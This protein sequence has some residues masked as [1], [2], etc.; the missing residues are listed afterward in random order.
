MTNKDADIK[1]QKAMNAYLGKFKEREMKTTVKHV[2]SAL[3]EW[4]GPEEDSIAHRDAIEHWVNGGEVENDAT[5]GWMIAH[6]SFEARV[7]YRIKQREPKPG[8]V[9]ID[10]EGDAIYIPFDCDKWQFV[11][12]IG[13][14][15]HKYPITDI[16][17]KSP[18]LEAY[19]ARKLKKECDDNNDLEIEAY[20]FIEKACNLGGE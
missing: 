1:R 8:E 11:D 16:K 3:R 15:N 17:Y 4:E 13:Y 10:E 12:K 2:G 7:N 20:S 19:Y 18:S 5:G 14:K 9:W 6:P